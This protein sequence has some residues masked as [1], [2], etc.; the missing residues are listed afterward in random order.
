MV[1]LKRTPQRR[2]NRYSVRNIEE[3]IDVSDEEGQFAFAS[4]TGTW[5]MRVLAGGYE[6]YIDDLRVEED[7][8][9]K[10]DISLS[11]M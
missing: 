10:K 3:E 9:T 2:W 1:E 6:F 4:P 11:F 7:Q 5:T 8:I